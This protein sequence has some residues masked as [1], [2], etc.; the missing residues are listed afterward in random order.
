M[1][2]LYPSIYKGNLAL[3][4]WTKTFVA[5]FVPFYILHPN[6]GGAVKGPLPASPLT[7]RP[8]A[9]SHGVVL[10]VQEVASF[11]NLSSKLPNFLLRT[12]L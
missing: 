3:S 7:G 6:T 2:Y 8:G 11:S 5:I 4:G 1:R 10:P 9:V 12:T